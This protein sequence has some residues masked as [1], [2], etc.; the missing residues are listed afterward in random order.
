ME[1]IEKLDFLVICKIKQ[2]YKRGDITRQRIQTNIYLFKVNN[3]DTGKK[4]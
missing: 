3:R 1:L 2:G 4:V